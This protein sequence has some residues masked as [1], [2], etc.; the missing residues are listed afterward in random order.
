MSAD[1][2][3]RIGTLLQQQTHNA[4]QL[5]KLLEEENGAL[6]RRDAEAIQRLSLEKG[7]RS[8]TLEQLGLQQ[9]QLF[10]KL[11]LQ[12]SA[13]GL[14]GFIQSLPPNLASQLRKKQQQLQSILEACQKLNLVNGNIIAAN[15]HS[16]ETALAILRGQ[17]TSDNLVY[18]ATGQTVAASSSKPI[19]KA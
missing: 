10:T 9:Q 4:E 7:E 12:N 14:K 3:L 16:A 1:A 18:S 2:A 17:F 6:T 13:E 19:M 8:I 5:Y 15:K 11:G